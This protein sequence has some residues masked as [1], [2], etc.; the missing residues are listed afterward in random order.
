M[1]VI[2]TEFGK[3]KKDKK[4]ISKYTISNSKGMKAKVMNLGANL[5]ELHVPDVVGVEVR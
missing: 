4:E 1:G 3:T 5:V 2:I